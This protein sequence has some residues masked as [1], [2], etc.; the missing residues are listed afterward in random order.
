MTTLDR[1]EAALTPSVFDKFWSRPF[2]EGGIWYVS[3]VG[4]K[5]GFGAALTEDAA[6][7][8]RNQ[9]ANASSEKVKHIPWC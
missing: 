3:P 1:M 4:S 6:I 9:I 2:S 5:Y 7:W 8:Q